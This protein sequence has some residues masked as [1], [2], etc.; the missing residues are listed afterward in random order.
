M[1]MRLVIFL[2][3]HQGLRGSSLSLPCREVCLPSFPFLTTPKP[4]PEVQWN[5]VSSQLWSHPGLFSSSH[6]TPT[7]NPVGS[8]LK[9]NSQEPTA[10]RPLLLPAGHATTASSWALIMVFACSPCSA[11][12]SRG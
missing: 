6:T 9:I 2:T 7:P 11:Q 12:H 10:S 5:H 8:V 3:A 4:K 1:S